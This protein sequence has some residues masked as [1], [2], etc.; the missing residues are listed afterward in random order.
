MRYTVRESFVEVVG[1]IWQPNCGLCAYRYNL[2]P[3]DV[4]NLERNGRITRNTVQLWIDSHAGDFQHIEDFRASIEPINPAKPTVEIP[5]KSEEN[6]MVF[7]DCMYPVE[8]D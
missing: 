4:Q 3:H 7:N 5:W 1:S 8:A 6:E 2:M